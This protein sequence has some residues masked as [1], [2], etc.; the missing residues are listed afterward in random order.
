M[1]IQISVLMTAFNAEKFISDSI[2]SILNQ[3]FKNFELIVIDDC[4]ID[5]TYSIIKNFQDKRIKYFKLKTKLGRT[6]A[7]N[8]GLKKCN[9]NLIA[10]QDADDVS[11]S[12]RLEET[13]KKFNSDKNIGLVCGNYELIDSFGNSLQKKIKF[14]EEKKLLSTI[15]YINQIAHSSITFNRDY[16][17]NQKKFVYDESYIYAQDYDLIL[18]FLKNSN[19]SL[20]NENLVKIRVHNENMSNNRIYKKTKIIE[21]LRLLDFTEKNLKNNFKEHLLIKYFKL[22]N[23][24]KLVFNYLG[25]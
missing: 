20:I 11:Y 22:K 7:L 13:F 23:N 3:Y 14:I 16:L 6:K 25:M 1:N 18:K 2:N 21:Y 19:I 15:K 12:I 4:S 9:S 5:N 24:L 8:Y 10:I 17:N